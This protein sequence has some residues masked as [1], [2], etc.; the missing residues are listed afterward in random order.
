MGVLGR[1]TGRQVS[2][3]S[4]NI[5]TP[6]CYMYMFFNARE[7]VGMS[8]CVLNQRAKQ[9]VHSPQAWR[10]D[11]KNNN[12]KHIIQECVKVSRI[13]FLGVLWFWI[14]IEPTTTILTKLRHGSMYVFITWKRTT[15]TM[16]MIA[17]SRIHLYLR[18][19]RL[20]KI[21]HQ[22]T[23]ALS[24]SLWSGFFNSTLSLYLHLLPQSAHTLFNPFRIKTN[25]N[26]SF[27]SAIVRIFPLM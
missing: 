26:F 2:K 11:M 1:S 13:L 22:R 23:Q 25:S 4:P 7:H 9:A 18:K 17:T 16:I 8:V 27:S 19:M 20:R 21:E 15:H 24:T 10:V 5:F 12:Q 3:R 6:C 14:L